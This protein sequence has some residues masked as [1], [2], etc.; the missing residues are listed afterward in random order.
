MRGLL[1]IG[2]TPRGR[3]YAHRDLRAEEQDRLTRISR[4]LAD[5]E[6]ERERSRRAKAEEEERKADIEKLEAQTL[7]AEKMMDRIIRHETDTQKQMHEELMTIL[8]PNAGAFIPDTKPEDD[9]EST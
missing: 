1:L 3:R 9:D 2:L 4:H 8:G 5:Y 6:F 7:R